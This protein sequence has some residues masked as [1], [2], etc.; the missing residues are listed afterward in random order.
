MW[1][2]ADMYDRGQ[3]IPRNDALASYWYR[4]GY[5][6]GSV[7]GN[8]CWR[9]ADCRRILARRPI[10]LTSRRTDRAR[11]VSRHSCSTW[12]SSIRYEPIPQLAGKAFL[13]DV[14]RN[15]RGS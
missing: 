14:L 15:D 2:L 1:F 5:E 13:I 4:V 11:T 6:A 12:P 9:R 8:W 7:K 10:R 3:E